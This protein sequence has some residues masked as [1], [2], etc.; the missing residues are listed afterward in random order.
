MMTRND[1]L[2]LDRGDPLAAFRLGFSLPDNV[3]YLDGNS[4][5]ALP[6]AAAAAVTRVVAHE[7]GEGLIRS[8]NSARWVDLPRRVGAKIA[9]LVGADPHSVI[10]TDSTSI[11]VFKVLA[12][13]LRLAGQ[14]PQVS[15]RARNVI[16]SERT[17]FPTDVYI[18]QGLVHL[19]GDR[20]EVRLVDFDEVAAAIDDRVAVLMLTHVNYRSGA[21]HD[22]QA[23][24]QRAQAMGAF[25][26]WDL[27]H[28]AG[29]LPVELDGALADFAV[30]CG[31]KFLNG[32]PGAPAFVYVAA[33]HLA[34]LA[35]DPFAQPL[36]GWFGHRAPFDFGMDY[37]PAPGIDR[38]AVGTPSIVALAALEAGVDSLLAAG[39]DALRAKSTALTTLFIELVESRCDGLG[40]ELASPRDP[41]RRGSQVSFAHAFAW[42]V[43]QALIAHQPHA[44]IGDCRRGAPGQPDLLRFGF[45]PLYVRHVDVW[46]AVEALRDILATRAWDDPDFLAPKAVT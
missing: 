33:R 44:V 1:S 16:L 39:I 41:A 15:T 34:A 40:L 30:G 27:A 19:L 13:A 23:L 17:N 9:R 7:W 21:I 24:T 2:D 28:S 12:C 32:G 10:C 37:A 31:Y 25:V 38:M 3:V 20:F 4:L 45:A 14:R 26:M 22:M 6:H 35:E 36:S 29:A 11:N 46:D 43:T 42:P 18:A 8:W 5:G